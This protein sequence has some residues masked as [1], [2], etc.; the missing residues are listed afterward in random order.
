M[1]LRQLAT[2]SLLIG[3]LAL[4]ASNS[5][6]RSSP[7]QENEVAYELDRGLNGEPES[8]SPGDFHSNQASTILRDIGEGLVRYLPSGEIDG[9]VASS[10][11]ISDDGR[12]YRFEIRSNARWSDGAPIVA[13]EFVEAFRELVDPSNGHRHAAILTPV[14]NAEKIIDGLNATE[15]LGVTAIDSKTLQIQLEAH[16]PQFLQILTHPSAFP[17]RSNAQF[18]DVSNGAY[19]VAERVLGSEILLAK[20]ES[21][22]NA[23]K[24]TYQSIRY[25]VVEETV[26]FNR[27]RAGELDITGNVPA[28]IFDTVQREYPNELKISP[29]L[30]VYYY[31]F[32]LNHKRFQSNLRLRKALNLAIDRD[33]LVGNILGRG[34][35][36]ALTW[37]PPGISGYKSP[38]ASWSKAE[39]RD[40]EVMARGL[41]EELGYGASNPL[42]FSLVYNTSDV[43]Q[44]IALAVQSMWQSVLGAQVELKNMEFK[45]LLNE[46]QHEPS[47]EI[48]RLSWTGDYIDPESFLQIFETDSPSNFT[49]FSSTK[50]D[51]LMRRSREEREVSKR[52]RLL[53]DAEMLV[54]EELPVVPLYFYVSKHLVDSDVVG[55]QDNVLDIHESQ[56]LQPASLGAV[57]D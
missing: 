39:Q 9:G 19:S 45:V 57:S 4:C 20:N 52:F 5:C 32:N 44:R 38:S 17:V 54:L 16:T 14:L 2:R 18:V 24:V 6:S 49:N 41:I 13:E 37:V 34:E 23:S 26:E 51:D 12:E 40:R 30:G 43:Q 42:S 36:P 53:A 33:A 1:H 25:H 10:W 28:A 47:V 56:Y 8:L 31:G 29:Y 46:I 55:W 35:M 11:T 27:F 7:D 15:D 50:F 21:Y 3:L 48:F 22:W